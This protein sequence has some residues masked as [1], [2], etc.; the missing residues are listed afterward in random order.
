MREMKFVNDLCSNYLAVSYSGGEKEFALRMMTENVANT[1]LPVELRRMDGQT[2]LYYNISGMQSMEILYGEKPMDR[3]TVEAFMWQLHEAIE[4]SRELFLPGDGIC[5]EPLFL[6][7]EL[8]TERWKFIYIPVPDEREAEGMRKGR[9][10][11]AEFLVTHIDYEDKELVE[12]VY[13]FYTEI[14][15]GIGFDR[16][17][18]FIGEETPQEMEE[19]NIYEA[20]AEEEAEPEK[21]EMAWEEADRYGERKQ[22]RLLRMLLCMAVAVTIVSGVI[23]PEM[24]LYGGAVSILLLVVLLV[25]LGRRRED[26]Q[27]KCST[28]RAIEEEAEELLYNRA[29]R[30]EFEEKGDVKGEKTVYV[31]I[32]SRTENKLY[33][34][35]KCR[36]Q[37]ISLDRLPCLVGKDGTLADHVIADPTVSRMH[38]K[39]SIEEETV[40]MQDLNSTNGTYHNG[41]RLAPNEKV[42]LEAEDEIRFGQAQF[43]FR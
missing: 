8:G 26:E 19:E 15:E 1:F 4:E 21:T 24:T 25:T 31:D 18:G 39:F 6:F 33:G 36:R 27:G 14:C 30:E 40:R 7:R 32:E 17:A 20:E 12:A 10:S 38:A 42:T 9:E 11:L 35:G 28:D 3:K 5:L 23:M 43:V 34:M 37:K 2:F 41:M 16:L 22:Q 29:D 13:R